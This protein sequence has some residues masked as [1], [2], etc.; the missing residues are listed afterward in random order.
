MTAEEKKQ[1]EDLIEKFNSGQEEI[2]QKNNE[3]LELVQADAEKNKETVDAL[4][5]EIAG[6]AAANVKAHEVLLKQGEALGQLKD[7]K[8]N[9]SAK[10]DSFS[11]VVLKAFEDNKE[12]FKNFKKTKSGFEM[13]ID[14][15][16]VDITNITNS[17]LGHR[18]PGIGKQPVRRVFVEDL[19]RDGNLGPDHNG[20][21]KYIDQENLTRNAD[22]VLRCN[23]VPESDITWIERSCEVKKVGDSI[24]VCEDALED[25]TFLEGELRNF[26]IENVFLK[27]D[28]NLMF[29]DGTGANLKGV[30][31]VAPDWAAGAQALSVDTPTVYDVISTSAKQVKVAGELGS[32]MPNWAL[33]NPEDV[34][35]MRLTKDANGNYIIPPFVDLDGQTIRGMR[36]VETT[37]VP[38]NE[39]YVGDFSKGIVYTARTMTIK[40]TDS[41]GTNFTS[42][43]LLMKATLRKALLIRQVNAG[44]FLHVPSITQ[45]ITDLTKP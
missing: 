8:F 10:N 28:E 21:I 45:A 37:L 19:F 11:D 9:I 43:I 39:M 14:L 44:A 40:M 33:M 34:E 23:P 38:A 41:H 25:L 30:D 7:V 32:Y 35:T 15:K 22:M 36:V 13:E 2:K 5:A 18:A 17:T 31:S 42:D 1:L 29:G 20:T 12:N 26:L 24:P 4:K 16:A 27:L 6:L 3:V